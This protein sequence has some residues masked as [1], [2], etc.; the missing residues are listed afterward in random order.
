MSAVSIRNP[1]PRGGYPVTY[2]ESDEMNESFSGL[3][4]D[5]RNL[6]T[7]VA[8]IK[9]EVR[10]TN[11]RLDSLRD[12]VDTGYLSLRDRIDQGLEKLRLEMK[13]DLG[14]LRTE[15][16]ALGGSLRGEIAELRGSLR[17]EIAG[18]GNSLR[19][20]IAEL[21]S[22]LQGQIDKLSDKLDAIRVWGFKLYIGG[23]A[24]LLVVMAHGFKW[25]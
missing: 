13:F 15:M 11:S 20:E 7:D 12:K 10:A 18:L 16:V 1:N 24:L 2:V 22:S 5:V 25:I 9:A 19:A 6:Q 17:A 23:M 21:R 4:A 3:C 14:T 8:D